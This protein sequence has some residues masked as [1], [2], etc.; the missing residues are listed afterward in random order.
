MMDTDDDSK[1]VSDNMGWTY[2]AV[3]SLILGYH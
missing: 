3:V 2:W 1:D